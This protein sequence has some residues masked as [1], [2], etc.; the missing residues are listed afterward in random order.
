MIRKILI[1]AA[2]I[3]CIISLS[4]KESGAQKGKSKEKETAFQKA[5]KYFYQEKFEMAEVLFQDELKTNPENGRAYSYLGDIY[6]MKKKY[7]DALDFYKKSMDLN[8]GAGE[9]YFRAGQIYYYKKN[10]EKAI[11]YFKESYKRDPGLKF[12]F[13]HIGLTYLML[14]RDKEN[15]IENWEKFLEIAPEDYQY[16][17]I[18]R[19]IELLRDPNFV[20]PPL[21]SDISIEEA[22]Q[23]G[24]T[25]LQVQDHK[26]DEKKAGHEDKKTKNKFEGIYKDDDL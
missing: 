7:D 20:I 11:D 19:A 6:F 4:V 15:T 18:K 9:D 1:W 16:A 5:E 3:F 12:A 25:T 10:P 2:V 23:L 21:G 17:K 26:A 8:S 24:G 13:Y 14:L 22:L